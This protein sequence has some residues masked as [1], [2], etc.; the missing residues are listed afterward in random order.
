MITATYNTILVVVVAAALLRARRTQAI[1]P[2]VALLFCLAA[3]A[4]AVLLGEDEF[5][6]LRL[7]AYG[8]FVHGVLLAAGTAALA[9]RSARG[10][11]AAVA[12]LA[13]VLLA[14]GVDA[15][16]IEPRW[17]TISR[18]VIPSAKVTRPLRIVVLADLQMDAFGDYERAALTAAMAERPDL[19][20]MP[21]DYIQQADDARF[22]AARDALQAHLR[23]IAFSAPL[24]VY[25]VQGNIERPRWTELFQGLPVTVFPVTGTLDRE[26]LS[27]TGLD[28]E[29]SFNETLEIAPSRRFHIVV[30]HGPDFA[31]GNIQADLL[32]AG[33]TH[34]GQVVLPLIGP[35][36]TLSKVPRS[37]AA[38]T[39]HLPGDRTLV[40][41]RGIG[42]ERAHAPRLRFLCRPE[43]V[44]IEVTPA[45]T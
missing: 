1:L 6:V 23:A 8:I 17:L 43:I 38:G 41:S 5:G 24:G 34:G 12:A 7:L 33:H 37:W 25:A 4:P 40:V 45:K 39:T 32:V 13:V 36:I 10:A 20:L 9:R 2:S 22:A 31:L 11:R 44:V 15:F 16:V 3:V 35:L 27:I 14:V 19:I 28:L 21:G 18:V 30:G 26:E 29:D 42:M